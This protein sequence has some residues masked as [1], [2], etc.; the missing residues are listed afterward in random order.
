Q[1]TIVD[2]VARNWP[3]EQQYDRLLIKK[4]RL[5]ARL[6]DAEEELRQKRERRVY[7]EGRRREELKEV[8]EDMFVDAEE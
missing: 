3:R 1:E 6:E 8:E 4:N 2:S 5:R 7:V